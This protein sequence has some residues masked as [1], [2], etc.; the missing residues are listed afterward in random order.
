MDVDVPDTIPEGC[1]CQ[2]LIHADMRGV[3]VAAPE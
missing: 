2:F 3:A 1:E